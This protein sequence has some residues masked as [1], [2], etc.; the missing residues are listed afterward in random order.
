[1]VII[2][3]DGSTGHD[4]PGVTIVTERPAL[5]ENRL[6]QLLNI[7]YA[8]KTRTHVKIEQDNA[9][10]SQC[11]QEWHSIAVNMSGLS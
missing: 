1:M 10:A 3:F 8:S 4:V 6:I 5:I 2:Y 11:K 9:Q 7:F